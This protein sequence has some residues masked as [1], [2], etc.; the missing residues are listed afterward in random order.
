MIDPNINAKSSVL[1]FGFRASSCR[2]ARRSLLDQ[3][4]A[5]GE[6]V[7]RCGKERLVVRWKNRFGWRKCVV[8]VGLGCILLLAAWFRIVAVEETVVD[9]PIRAD[10]AEYYNSAYN[11]V[12]HGTYSRSPAGLA[13]PGAPLPADA[14]RYPGLPLVIAAFIWRDHKAILSTVPTVNVAAVFRD[15][16]MVNI[17]AGVAAVALIFFAANLALPAW[18]ALGTAL[19][20]A[21]SPHLVSFTVYLLTEPISAMLT[22]LLLATAAAVALRGERAPGWGLFVG[23]GIIVGVLAMFRPI[24]LLFA[25]VI[26]LAFSGRYP[27]RRALVGALIG[28]VL[29]VS[30]WFVRNAV[31]V[32]GRGDFG[33]LASALVIGAYPGDMLNGRPNTLPN[34]QGAKPEYSKA[35]TDISSAVGEIARRFAADPGGM[36]AWYGFGKMRYLWQWDNMDGA[37]DVFIYPVIKTPFTSRAVF[38]V[39]HDA[40]KASYYWLIALALTGS[41]AVWIPAARDLLPRRGRPVLRAASLLLAYTTVILIPLITCTRYAV[42]VF[43]ALFMM[44]M[45]PPAMVLEAIARGRRRSLEPASPR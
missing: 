29:T 8:W 13:N 37:G 44:A 32:T 40:M 6:S 31:S 21:I 1:I 19:L 18:A 42:P 4:V 38:G 2:R 36:A 23:I 7:R 16:H 28:T 25:P 15:V 35:R 39:M 27:L 12:F 45:V 3:Q 5:R 14:Y 34:P 20:T 10:A 24:Y 26:V 22:C 9:R 43:P 33:T 17:V 41:I 11:L 30:P